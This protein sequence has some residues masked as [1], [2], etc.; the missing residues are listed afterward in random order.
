[1]ECFDGGFEWKSEF[2]KFKVGVNFPDPVTMV[3]KGQQASSCPAN[4]EVKARAAILGNILIN[5]VGDFHKQQI[6]I[7]KTQIRNA[8]RFHFRCHFKQEHES[9]PFWTKPHDKKQH[10]QYCIKLLHFSD[11]KFLWQMF[12]S[13]FFKKLCN[14]WSIQ[15]VDVLL[16]YCFWDR[17]WS[18]NNIFATVSTGRG[19][20]RRTLSVIEVIWYAWPDDCQRFIVKDESLLISILTHYKLVWVTI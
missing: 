16:L 13:G 15:N 7:T 1:M 18:A 12:Q 17:N 9:F 11:N 19:E 4:N 20:I 6:Q 3:L 2:F 14:L 5:L 8:A 10:L